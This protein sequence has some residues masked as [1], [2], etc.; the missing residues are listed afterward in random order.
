MNKYLKQ[1]I[2]KIYTYSSNF[3]IKLSE[4]EKKNRKNLLFACKLS[5]PFSFLTFFLLKK[6]TKQ[7]ILYF[8]N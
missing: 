3:V 1:I 5:L 8:N 6:I 4:F 2:L 7:I